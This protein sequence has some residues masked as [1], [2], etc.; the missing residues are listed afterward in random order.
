M[1]FQHSNVD[2]GC[3]GHYCHTCSQQKCQSAFNKHPEGLHRLSS[4]CQDC[5]R[6]IASERKKAQSAP[7]PNKQPPVEPPAFQHVDETCN[8]VGKFCR[9]CAQ[10]KCLQAFSK[11]HKGKHGV[12]SQCKAC[13]KKY[14]QAYN[15]QKKEQQRSEQE[16]IEIPEFQHTDEACSCKGKYCRTCDH[17]KCQQAFSRDH[18]G[19]NGFSATCKECVKSYQQAHIDRIN[20]R[21]RERWQENTERYNA[22]QQAYH[23]RHP[24]R[25][26]ESDRKYRLKHTEEAQAYSKVYRARK[27]TDADF[28]ARKREYN[29]QYIQLR[30]EK[31]AQYFNNRRARVLQAEGSF[32]SKEWKKLCKYYQYTCLCCRKCE[33]EIKLTVDHVIPLSRG[34]S[35]SIENLQPLCQS[36][37][38]SKSTQIIDYRVNWP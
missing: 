9:P 34:G 33:P 30:P 22:R 14:A 19:A 13:T 29:Q 17:W 8:C 27:K 6:Q 3:E 1:V 2:C 5:Q 20:E 36:C 15:K 11:N 18:K 28:R 10:W 32:T 21:R 26:K 16:K 38:S 12:K 31:S 35:N 37:N 24:E 7:G 25:K 23:D 4:H